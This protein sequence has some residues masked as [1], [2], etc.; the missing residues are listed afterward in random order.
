MAL[1]ELC[2]R[3]PL[4]CPKS[5]PSMPPYELCGFVDIAGTDR[6][7]QLETPHFP[8]TRGL[9]ITS[10]THLQQIAASCN[11]QLLK[12]RQSSST[13]LE[14][15]SQF[16]EICSNAAKSVARGEEGEGVA[17]LN[18]P[19]VRCLLAHLEGIGWSK[20]KEVAPNF[21]SFTLQTTDARGRVHVLRVKAGDG[22]PQEEPRVDADLP[23]GLN[24]SYDQVEGVM[25]VVGA[26]EG[27]VG[28][29]QE[30]WDVLDHLDERAV[31][32]DPHRP[33]R[34]H[35][36]RRILLR[37]H[38]NVQVS[39]SPDQPRHLPHCLLFG[40]SKLTRPM[41]THLTQTFEA[42]DPERN[43]IE[44]LEH[45]LGE[46]VVVRRRNVD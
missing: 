13:V 19:L 7:V 46:K 21:T 18:E 10:D 29:L 39:L 26:W 40:P 33:H 3:F 4:L 17:E 42:W 16:Q 45:L 24:Y 32:L 41:G 12:A 31:V 37:N 38:V 11:D 25:G 6:E 30:F 2:S 23:D 22:Y 9:H 1:W 20:V 27:R 15:L 43:I 5:L 34:H 36:F 8:H 14:F 44:N 35:T 28:A